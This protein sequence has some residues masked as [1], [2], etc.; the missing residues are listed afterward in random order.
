MNIINNTDYKIS[1]IIQIAKR[2]NNKKRSFLLVNPIQAKHIPCSPNDTLKLFSSLGKLLYNKYK[3]EKVCVIGF[4]E[5]ATAVS[6]SVATALGDNTFYIHTTRNNIDGMKNIITFNEEHS[7]AIEQNLFC[8][9]INSIINS[10]RIIFVDDEISTGKT[11]LNFIEAMKQKN[12]IN[13]DHKI[14][15]ASIIN[16][17]N[18]ENQKLFETMDIECSYLVKINTDEIVTPN[19]DDT[20]INQK[21]VSDIDISFHQFKGKLSPATGVIIK[22][23]NNACD[24]LANNILSSISDIKAKKILVLGTEE[25][26]YPAIILAKKISDISIDVKIHATTRSPIEVHRDNNYP[27]N[28]RFEFKSFYCDNTKVF[29]YNLAQY[30][31][32]IILTDSENNLCFE[33]GI[34][35]LLEQFKNYG[36]KSTNIDIV[37]W[38][39]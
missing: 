37:S 13:K 9:D 31:K 39:Q 4:A 17:M 24:N 28:M 12:Y 6:A 19:L 29:L 8:K 11:I 10:N 23:Y 3:D 20:C 7:H 2:D 34:N 33:N 14:S 26:M 36:F 30:D 5:T 25:F 1:D 27:L 18:K 15:V 32:I 16:G 22:D 38:L 35:S 21:N